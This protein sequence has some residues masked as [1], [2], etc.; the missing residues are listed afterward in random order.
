MSQDLLREKVIGD[1]T[2]EV[3]MLDPDTALELFVDLFAMFGPSLAALFEAADEDE[4]EGEGKEDRAIAQ[5]VQMLVTNLSK[6]KLKNA[7]A[8]LSKVSFIDGAPLAATYKVHFAGKLGLM[9]RWLAYA[10][11]VQFADFQDAFA[12]IPGLQTVLRQ[13]GTHGGK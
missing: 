2:F 8:V 4:D 3:R 10:L 7:V 5:A 11:Q 12:S 1:H 9:V 6:A 13:A